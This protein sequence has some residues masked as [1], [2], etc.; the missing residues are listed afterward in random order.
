MRHSEGTAGVQASSFK[1][2]CMMRRVRSLGKGRV[3]TVRFRDEYYHVFALLGRV[4]CPRNVKLAVVEECGAERYG[5]G[6]GTS[7]ERPGRHDCNWR[8]VFGNSKGRVCI[9]FTGFL[10][11]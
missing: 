11:N 9:S 4:D 7:E 3:S 6:L 1:P 5:F 2:R 8:G 10:W